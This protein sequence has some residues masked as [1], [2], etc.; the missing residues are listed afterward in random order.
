MKSI[1][2]RLCN[3]AFVSSLL[4]LFAVDSFLHQNAERVFIGKMRN[5]FRRSRNLSVQSTSPETIPNKASGK[6]YDPE[7]G[8]IWWMEGLKFGCTA[9]GKC[10]QNEGEVWMDSDEFADLAIHLKETPLSVLDKYSERVQK[11]WVKMKSQGVDNSASDATTNNRCIFLKE[12]GKECSIYESRP[13]QCRTYPFWPRLLDSPSDWDSESVS[14]AAE[15]I[16]TDYNDISNI[17]N[18][19]HEGIDSR[20]MINSESNNIDI[21]CSNNGVY[22]S[23]K[24]YGMEEYNNSEKNVN[25]ISVLPSKRYWTSTTG[26]CEGIE[27]ADATVIQTKTIHRNQEL[28]KMYTQTFPFSGDSSDKE[29]LLAKTSI[30]NVNTEQY[31]ENYLTD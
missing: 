22:N 24:I 29:K 31:Q 2:D 27:H 1:L 17:Y 15:D 6:S 16:E 21:N 3:F 23:I 25:A 13:I 9:C 30:V 28:Y 11:G 10:C 5:D 14:V 26:G 8:E 19:N 20:T 12:N 7:N 18:K 4:S